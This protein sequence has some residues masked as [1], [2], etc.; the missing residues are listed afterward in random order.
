MGC[1]RA[2]C[3]VIK[4]FEPEGTSLS[5]N[6]RQCFAIR[7]MRRCHATCGQMASRTK[8]ERMCSALPYPHVPEVGSSL[9][10]ESAAKRAAKFGE[11]SAL[12]AGAL[13]TVPNLG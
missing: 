3:K 8:T 7:L 6:C 2:T 9:D 10:I 12:S 13:H 11:D 1:A 5:V 4:T